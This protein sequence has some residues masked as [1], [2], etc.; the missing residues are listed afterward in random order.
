MLATAEAN[1]EVASRFASDAFVPREQTLATRFSSS[2][3]RTSTRASISSE[4][5]PV[6]RAI[7][8]RSRIAADMLGSP[9]ARACSAILS[10]SSPSTLKLILAV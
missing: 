4:S 9:S 3:K 10:Y 5:E 1:V 6:S 2:L 8:M 7:S